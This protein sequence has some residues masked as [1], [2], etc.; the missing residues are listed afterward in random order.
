MA[1]LVRSITIEDSNGF[2]TALDSV[3]RE[4]RFLALLEAPPLD[5][6][7]RFL[8]RNLDCGSIQLIAVENRTIV[9]WCDIILRQD[10]GFTHIGRVGLGVVE[11][12][13]R[14]GIGRMLLRE[15]LERVRRTGILRVELE[16]FSSNHGAI[17]LYRSLGFVEEGRRRWA[18]YLDGTWDDLV[19]MALLP[20]AHLTM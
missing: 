18:R 5:E 15:A 7:E 17:S 14:R 6:I 16:V 3:A 8:S 1:L 20:E 19:M 4:R 11:S 2:R 12:Y 10:I 9:G 13:R